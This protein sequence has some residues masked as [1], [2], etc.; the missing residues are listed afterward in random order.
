MEKTVAI[1]NTEVTLRATAGVLIIYKEQFGSEYISDMAELNNAPED[2]LTIGGQLVWA[3]AKAAD[4]QIPPPETWYKKIG[5]FDMDI[6]FSEAAQLFDESCKNID[7]D[8]SANK[9]QLTS[10]NLVTSALICK[11]TFSD[12]SRL[13]LSMALNVIN[14]YCAVRSGEERPHMAT[15]EDF[16]NF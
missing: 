16:D 10:E 5:S 3:M 1:G 8:S 2:F 4:D 14:E 7:T 13:S 12:L 6:V 9:E 15:Q 11:M